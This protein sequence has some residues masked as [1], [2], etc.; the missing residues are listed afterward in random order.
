MRVLVVP[1]AGVD[2]YVRP[3]VDALR[4]SYKEKKPAEYEDLINRYY[5][6]LSNTKR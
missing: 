5:S 1:G 4:Q 3:A 2:R 6:A